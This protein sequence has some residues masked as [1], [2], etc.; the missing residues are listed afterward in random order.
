M[1]KPSLKPSKKAS[2][3]HIKLCGKNF[4]S[5]LIFFSSNQSCLQKCC[6]FTIFFLFSAHWPKTASGLPSTA[7]TTASIA[8]IRRGKIYTGHVGDSAIVLGQVGTDDQWEGVGLTRE[9]KP[10]CPIERK[11]IDEAGGKVAVKSG[12]PRVVWKRPKMGHKGAIR[13]STPVDE[14]P[15]LAVARSLG[16]PN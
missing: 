14:I 2:F 4:V 13:R 6:V 15:F 8:F 3:K 9:H 12:V 7:G 10:E 16:K 1:M 5:F 11:R